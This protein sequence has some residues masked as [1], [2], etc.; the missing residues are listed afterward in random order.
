MSKLDLNPYLFFDGE[1]KTAMEF[2]KSIFGGKLESM[3]YEKLPDA[4]VLPEQKGRLIHASLSGGEIDLMAS[5]ITGPI[6]KGNI[7]LSLSG[8]DEPKLRHMFKEL[9][10]GG[11]V[12]HPLEPAFWGVIHGNLTDKFG[13]DWMFTIGKEQA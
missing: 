3:P 6:G 10:A 8:T 1:C 5:D 9:S 12:N 4:E 7:S 11:K 13:I 2:Y